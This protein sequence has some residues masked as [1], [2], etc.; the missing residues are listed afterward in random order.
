MNFLWHNRNRTCRRD[1]AAADHLAYLTWRRKDPAG[2]RIDD[3]TWDREVTAVNRFY[4]WQVSAKKPTRSPQRPGRDDTATY[5]HG[6]GRE[7]MSGCRRR[8]IAGGATSGC[9]ATSRTACLTTVSA[10]TGRHAM[11]CL[12]T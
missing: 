11:R 10:V 1:A 5:S 6:A 4:A 12:A 2:P 9:A 3:A 7:K 8:S